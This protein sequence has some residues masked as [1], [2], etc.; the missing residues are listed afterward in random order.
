MSELI[1]GR[2]D[3]QSATVLRKALRGSS[4]P[5][6]AREHLRLVE[7][8]FRD[9]PGI[10]DVGGQDS[11]FLWWVAARDADEQARRRARQRRD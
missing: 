4:Q 10:V 7:E 5:K 1:R 6:V 2:R 8:A 9:V 3:S 11:A